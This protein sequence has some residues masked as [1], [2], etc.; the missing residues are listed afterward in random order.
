MNNDVA[1]MVLVEQVRRA[2]ERRPSRH[3]LDLDAVFRAMASVKR[4]Q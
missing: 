2:N 3:Q 1:L 4:E